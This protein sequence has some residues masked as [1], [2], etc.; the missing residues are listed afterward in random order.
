MHF[1]ND[2]S[3]F[4]IQTETWPHPCIIVPSE[5][6]HLQSETGWGIGHWHRTIKKQKQKQGGERTSSMS[7]YNFV[8][9]D[10][11]QRPEPPIKNITC[12]LE[13]MTVVDFVIVIV[14]SSALCW[15]APCHYI[16]DISAVLLTHFVCWFCKLTWK[17]WVIRS[18]TIMLNPHFLACFGNGKLLIWWYFVGVEGDCSQSARDLLWCVW[19]TWRSWGSTY[20]G[21]PAHQS[22][23]GE[24]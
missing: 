18:M 8:T 1:E 22:P 20:G 3:P 24:R 14:G 7:Q 6:G 15:C 11:E 17:L 2:F 4:R 23:A 19:W 13:G 10:T 21:R 12:F 5:P 9:R 16:P